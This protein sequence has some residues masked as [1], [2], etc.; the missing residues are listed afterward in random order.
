MTAAFCALLSPRNFDPTNPQVYRSID[1]PLAK[2]VLD[3]LNAAV[4]GRGEPA[5]N[6]VV[7][8][9]SDIYAIAAKL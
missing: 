5:H 4:E 9:C 3:A 1:L 2:R 7:A 6:A 8:L